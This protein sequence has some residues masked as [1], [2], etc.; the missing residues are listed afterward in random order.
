M[1]ATWSQSVTQGQN[2]TTGNRRRVGQT[3][4]MN[5]GRPKTYRLKEQTQ[6]KD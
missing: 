5:N 6:I 2:L 3:K 4:S 1:Y